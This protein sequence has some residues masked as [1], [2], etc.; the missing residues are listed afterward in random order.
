MHG[1]VLLA[2]P[3]SGR[4]EVVATAGTT[5]SLKVNFTTIQTE[6]KKPEPIKKKI[7]EKTG[8]KE[9]NRPVAKKPKPV[10]RIV[11]KVKAPVVGKKAPPEPMESPAPPP[12]E[13]VTDAAE[14]APEPAESDLPRLAKAHAPPVTIA[15]RAASI[16][17]LP[18]PKYPR[19]SVRSG[20]KGIVVLQVEIMAD[21]TAGRVDVVRSSSYRRLDSA[22]VKA[23]GKAKFQPAVNNGRTV[24]STIKITIRFEL[25]NS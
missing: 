3:F 16:V 13:T 14:S 7:P 5:K 4:S 20:E 6:T 22:A 24:S 23:V 10:K 1:L 9:I 21:G 2:W 8:K 15:D 19:S 17:D 25:K 18:E 11:K 12:Q